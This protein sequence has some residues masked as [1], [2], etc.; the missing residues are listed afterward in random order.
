[1][2][3]TEG[4]TP[5]RLTR[6]GTVQYPPMARMQKVEGTVITSVLVF[7]DRQRHRSAESCAS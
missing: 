3:R 2:R 6:R 5:P 1:M 4:L 7:R